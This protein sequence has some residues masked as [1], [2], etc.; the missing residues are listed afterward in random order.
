MTDKRDPNGNHRQLAAE[1]ALGV[2]EGDELAQARAMAGSNADF[3]DE[4]ARW[5]GRLAPLLDEIEPAA[6]PAAAW[7]R[8]EALI[9]D[10]PPTDNVV[11]LKRRIGIWRGIAATA[12]ALAASLAIVL[13]VQ[14]QA[15]APPSPP[16]P[17]APPMVAMVGDQKQMMVVASWDPMSRQL[18]LAVAG[19]MPADPSHSHEL[20]V[21]P[22]GGKPRS[23]GVMGDAKQT[24]MQLAEALAKLMDEGATVAISV[25]PRGGSPTGSPTGPVVASGSLHSA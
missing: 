14:P 4:V 16:V 21:I 13:L 17:T 12:M 11:A 24:H 19:D 8:I 20:W 18:V 6:P 10:R 23:L 15:I 9:D 5:S 2:L 1:F 3:R 25:E 7:R 22:S